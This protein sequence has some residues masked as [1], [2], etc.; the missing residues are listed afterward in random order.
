VQRESKNGLRDWSYI[1]RTDLTFGLPLVSLLF[2]LSDLV[3]LFISFRNCA[4]RLPY[5][6]SGARELRQLSL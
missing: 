3:A 1:F 5:S 2:H 4:G 6:D